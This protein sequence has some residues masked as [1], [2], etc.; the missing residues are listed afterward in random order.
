V[1]PRDGKY[2]SL[3]EREKLAIYVSHAVANSRSSQT[4]IVRT[5]GKPSLVVAAIQ[6]QIRQLDPDLAVTAA[7]TLDDEVAELA[8]T[9]LVGASLLSWFSLM[10]VALTVVG[11]YGLIAYAV[12]LRAHEIGIPYRLGWSGI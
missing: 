5:L 2:G 4:I 9:Q 3:A 8:M 7:G 6:R 11:V 10:A 12:A 1:L